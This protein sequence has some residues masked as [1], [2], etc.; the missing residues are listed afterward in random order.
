MPP[1]AKGPQFTCLNPG[2][3]WVVLSCS[4]ICLSVPL[5]LLLL[6]SPT[7]QTLPPP[8][9]SHVHMDLLQ[10][11]TTECLSPDPLE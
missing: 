7:P 3:G 10:A 5:L 6:P 11:H 1:R 4:H 2:L 8:P 9:L